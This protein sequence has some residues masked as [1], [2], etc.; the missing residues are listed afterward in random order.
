MNILLLGATGQT[1]K[2]LLTQALDRGYSVTAL[3]RS[4]GKL[5]VENERLDIRVGS[6]TDPAAVQQALEDQDAVLSTLGARGLRELFG[7]DLITRSMEAIVPAMERSGASRLIF[8]SALGV[9]GSARE[10]P[11]VLRVV[12]GTALRRIAKDKAAGED[13]LRRSNLDWTLVYPP[14]LTNGPRTGDYRVGEDLRVKATGKIS[15]AD[16]ADFM[17]G[18]VEDVTY[19]RTQAIISQ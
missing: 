4:P 16:V 19:S 11:A 17:L 7:T 5:E 9:G 6:V 10:A 15:R 18:Q 1:G 3:V 8:M 12:M 14:S 13:Q 2:E